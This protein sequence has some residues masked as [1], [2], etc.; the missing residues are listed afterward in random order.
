MKTISIIQADE[1]GPDFR[2]EGGI[3]KVNFP[4]GNEPIKVISDDVG[5]AIKK[6]TDGGGFI[7]EDLLS[8]YALVQDTNAQKIHLY[9]FPAG[10]EFDVTTA[11][12][13]ST[14]NLIEMNGVFDDVAIEDGV[15]TFTDADTGQTLSLDTRTLQRIGDIKA[16]EGVTVSE[17]N[18]VLTIA[19]KLLDSADN[20]IQSTPEGLLVSKQAL[21]GLV[22]GSGV[23][24]FK[25]KVTPMNNGEEL[26]VVV[27]NEHLVI[28]QMAIANTSGEII[29]LFDDIPEGGLTSINAT[30]EHCTGN[31]WDVKY[32]LKSTGEVVKLKTGPVV[33]REL[34]DPDV[35][36]TRNSDEGASYN[37]WEEAVA[38]RS[39]LY[40]H[41]NVT[42][43]KER[44]F[45]NWSGLEKVHTDATE[46]E[47]SAF[48]GSSSITELVFLP[49]TRRVLGQL[50]YGATFSKLEFQE[51]VQTLFRSCVGGCNFPGGTLIIPDSVTGYLDWEWDE[52]YTEKTLAPSHG[53]D[54]IFGV[55]KLIIGGGVP[56]VDGGSWGATT[57]EL[58]Y[59]E[60]RPGITH[61]EG[62]WSAN[63]TCE[64]LIFPQGLLV[65]GFTDEGSQGGF[66][67]YKKL[68]E[69]TIPGTV[70]YIGKYCF[71]GLEALEKLTIERG[72]GVIGNT[73]FSN[74]GSEWGGKPHPIK[75]FNFL[76]GTVIGEAAFQNWYLADQDFEIVIPDTV[77]E[78]RKNAF[79][80]HYNTKSLRFAEGCQADVGYYAFGNWFKA[81]KLHIAD[82]VKSI[83]SSF[84]LWYRGRELY[85]GKGIKTLGTMVDIWGD[86]NL[87]IE[88][89]FGNWGSDYSNPSL[90]HLASKTIIIPD[91]VETILEAFN[92]AS[93][94]ET[95]IVSAGLKQLGS[96]NLPYCKN[97]FIRCSTAPEILENCRLLVGSPGQAV[98]VPSLVGY[99]SVVNETFGVYTP[100][101]NSTDP[102]VPTP[103]V[104]QEGDWDVQYL[105]LRTGLTH[106]LNGTVRGI[107]DDNFS[108]MHD[109]DLID[110]IVI[111]ASVT[112]IGS[113]SFSKS[114]VKRILFL[115]NN[116]KSIGPGAFPGCFI[117]GGD[118]LVLPDSLE[119]VGAS[120]F[121]TLD[122]LNT[123]T[124]GRNLI[125][126]AD[127]AFDLSDKFATPS[128]LLPPSPTFVSNTTTTIT[129]TALAGDTIVGSIKR[130]E[131]TIE[132]P[133]TPVGGDG[134]FTIDLST[135]E[136]PVTIQSGDRIGLVVL[137]IVKNVS[138]PTQ[139]VFM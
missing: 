87:R 127:G 105:D 5:N 68:K 95:L 46:L 19:V 2:L 63:D 100:P 65:V 11:T 83:N 128:K 42:T 125:S 123:L 20:L 114:S 29:A 86:G 89:E 72:V 92:G 52:D 49:N 76:G 70:Q 35:D 97:L 131:E 24:D 14:V 37:A 61:V 110:D 120:A 132:L 18:G 62:Y 39:E 115:G 119:R 9:S 85:I 138:T 78:I 22:E 74:Y 57:G 108:S 12:L 106:T 118:E 44:A 112:H 129:G 101:L 75:E 137:D 111:G 55:E 21:Q 82:S 84:G 36:F 121:A 113:S 124:Y 23:G 66:N 90:E 58:K 116:L 91:N 50:L 77:T 64:E 43:V 30:D 126:V 71:G 47:E 130:G 7:S 122:G 109:L 88:G 27:G 73:A 60:F 48:M 67:G 16:G 139:V 4:A 28:P 31:D 79:Q 26:C 32:T 33:T 81:E 135:L 136:E 104:V 80:N 41:R 98:Y 40:I 15:L 94:V 13:V 133:A 102:H 6:G 45:A 38:D 8:A 3:W 51:G 10:T 53:V 69:L 54:G 1:L 107:I 56:K 134:N 93:Q 17:L 59:L 117:F 96:L 34:I 25:Q 103:I 99:D